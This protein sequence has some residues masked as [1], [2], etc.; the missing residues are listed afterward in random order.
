M[1]DP[2]VAHLQMPLREVKA[3]RMMIYD[4]EKNMTPDEIKA[5]YKNLSQKVYDEFGIKTVASAR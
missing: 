4:E 3:I 2:S 5:K 1:D